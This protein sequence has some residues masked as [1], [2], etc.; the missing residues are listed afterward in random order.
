M[1][2][3]NCYNPDDSRYDNLCGRCIENFVELEPSTIVT[4]ITDQLHDISFWNSHLELCDFCQDLI[5]VK[6]FTAPSVS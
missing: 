6:T 2:I 1:Q 3:F 5:R 4:L